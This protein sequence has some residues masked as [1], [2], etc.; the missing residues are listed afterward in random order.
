MRKETK[1]LNKALARIVGEEWIVIEKSY[2]KVSPR[3]SEEVSQI[4]KVANKEKSPVTP[5]GGGTGWW[6]KSRP[7]AGGILMDM[8]RMNEVRVIDEDTLT[9]TAEA[10]I[11]FTKLESQISEKGYRLVLFPESGRTATLGGH[12][13]TWGTSPYASSG[14]EDQATQIV[15]LKVVLPTGE[16][17][18]TG[19]GAVKSAAGN[20]ARRFFPADLTGIFIGA[21]GAFGIITEATLKMHK[22]PEA[23]ITRMIGFPA[24][25]GAVNVLR[26][27]QETQ[28]KGGLLTIGEQRLMQREMLMA[29]IPRI[30]ELIREDL[31]IVLTIRGDGDAVDVNHHLAQACAIAAKQGGI[32]VEDEFPEWWEG[33]Y[34]LISGAIKGPRIMLV[35]MVP[36]GK[37]LEASELTQKIGQEHGTHIPMLGYPISGPIMLAHAIIP[38]GGPDAHERKKALALARKLMEA[39]MDIGGVPH[40]VG[41]DFLP[42]IT[43]RLDAAYYDFIKKIKRVLDPKGIMNPDLVIAG[44]K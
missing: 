9:V 40:R 41:T 14:F 22:W 27:F 35:A 39:L 34:K 11:S 25:G 2:L 15:A 16:I 24:L 19:S 23:I 32:V 4:L 21:E 38:V 30:K 29:V 13:E 18:P 5:R 26:E 33:R 31:K 17:V 37:F 42:V 44:G 1:Q 3:T 7:R 43:K 10:G 28:R 6:S 20:F 12:I 8:T 36:M